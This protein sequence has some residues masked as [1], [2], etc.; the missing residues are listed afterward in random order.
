MTRVRSL[1]LGGALAALAFPAAAEDET[2]VLDNAYA[3]VHRN[4]AP[5]AESGPGCGDRVVVAFGDVRIAA[6]GST[7]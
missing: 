5:C 1:L 4:A 7:V 2:L 6:G 3:V